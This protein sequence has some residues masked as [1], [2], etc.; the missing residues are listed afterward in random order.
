MITSLILE[1]FPLDYVLLSSGE[2]LCWLLLAGI[3]IHFFSESWARQLS[4]MACLPIYNLGWVGKSAELYKLERMVKKFRA[5]WTFLISI[6]VLQVA[7]VGQFAVEARRC[8]CVFPHI[9]Q[10]LRHHLFAKHLLKTSRLKVCKAPASCWPFFFLHESW[11]NTFKKYQI[12]TIAFTFSTSSFLWMQCFTKNWA[13]D[14]FIE[15]ATPSKMASKL[16]ISLQAEAA[17]YSPLF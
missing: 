10:L 16:T 3:H 15:N 4:L 17:C 12:L 11:R 6:Y 13:W 2:N 7:M 1:I 9:R 14:H 5:T 8:A